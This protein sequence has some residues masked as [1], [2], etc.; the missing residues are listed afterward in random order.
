MTMSNESSNLIK[1]QNNTQ[2]KI[3][4]LMPNSGFNKDDQDKGKPVYGQ[5]EEILLSQSGSST[6]DASG[7]DQYLLDRTYTDSKGKTQTALLYDL[8]FSEATFASPILNRSVM[9]NFS[10]GLFP[11]TSV[12][13][14]NKEI[15]DK[16]NTF[17]QQ[18]QAYPNS[19]M[20]KNYQAALN[21]AQSS[22]QS[23][24]ASGNVQKTQQSIDDSV[25]AFFKTTKNYQDLTL[26]D[27][28]AVENYYQEFPF[29]WASYT[30]KK[31]WLYSSDG[32]SSKFVGLI[33]MTKPDIIDL[34][35]ANGGYDVYLQTAKKP[36]DTSSVDVNS[37]KIQLTYADGVFVDDVN[38]DVPQIGLSG[39]LRLKSQITGSLGTS[40][41]S[42]DVIMPFLTG[43]VY[44]ATCL[45]MDSAH[46]SESG[47]EKQSDEFWNTLFHPK[48]SQQVFQSI[49][50]IGGA[51]MMFHFAASTLWSTSKWLKNKLTKTEEDPNL[52]KDLE[53]QFEE[54]QAQQNAN[55]EELLKR[56]ETSKDVSAPESLDEA[57]SEISSESSSLDASVQSGNMDGSITELGTQMGEALEDLGPEISQDMMIQLEESATS[58][59]DVS[60]SIDDA[61][62]KF[63][64]GDITPEEF[65]QTISDINSGSF[66]DA[67][68]QANETTK[69]LQKEV[70]NE[71]TEALQREAQ[72]ATE[73]QEESENME[74]A[75]KKAEEDASGE[76]MSDDA[77]DFPEI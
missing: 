31:F 34:G 20:A 16:A 74:E 43:T 63:Q 72:N 28:V 22:A 9:A 21:G 73:V 70:Q 49:M 67:I 23:T 24:A 15:M 71:Q 56:L 58:L 50:E 47:D 61:L 4:T 5:Q 54:F 60:N 52:S 10:T 44:G 33:T 18:I 11:D 7:S 17:Y 32:S 8:I 38:A 26:S 42:D 27:V 48:T 1:V 13:K 75:N 35:K 66:K 6:I 39:I 59:K 41:P 64:S 77:E 37:E 29:V 68:D 3:L 62:G 57:M 12:T 25:E 45:G 76:D 53:T 19:Q 65:A 69:S 51:L 55:M 46:T 30:S 2:A 40:N 14:S 36:T